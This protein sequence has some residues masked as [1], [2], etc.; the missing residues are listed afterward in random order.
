MTSS[1]KRPTMLDIARAAGVSR[2]SVSIAL[3]DADGVSAATKRKIL[4]TA[5]EMGYVRDE[6]ARGLRSTK[7][8]IIGVS[9][10]TRQP[11]QLE[12]VEGFYSALRGQNKQMVLSARS[13]GRTE[14]EAIESLLSF[15]S[16]V[17][18]LISPHLSERHL[19]EIAKTVP[20]VTVGRQIR[21]QQI[22][23]ISSD[24]RGGM[25]AAIGHLKDLGHEDIV[26]L[27]S[28]TLPAGRDRLRAFQEGVT[29]HGM[30][31]KVRLESGGITEEDG[32][33]AAENLLKSG[34][35][36]TAVIGFND[37]CALGVIETFLRAGV[38]VPE[39]VSIVGFD[40]SEIA[41]R[42]SISMTSVHQD[43]AQLAA[44]GIERALELIDSQPTYSIPRGT[45]VPT[46][47]SI[48]ATTGP[49]RNLR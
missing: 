36:P 18:L 14:D 35:L 11:F 5:A 33:A 47:L 16:G 22:S 29:A 4:D 32:I 24:D 21:A 34:R 48:R 7:S 12:V 37:R 28:T 41:S 42:K 38:S 49:A 9:F 39:E 30:G 3:R 27:S 15:R 46:S 10:D 40:D 44:T 43:P 2:A 26:Y 19:V 23:W 17:L 31:E 1:S 45:L 13:L 6:S 25:S 8:T 20:V